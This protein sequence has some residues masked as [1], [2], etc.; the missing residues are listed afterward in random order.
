[1]P[2]PTP[3]RRS[4]SFTDYQTANPASPEP[5]NELDAQMNAVKV[6]TDSII[7]NLGL[8]QS[9]SGQLA[10]A[11][12]G[13]QQL[14]RCVLR[15]LNPPT[16][17]SSSAVSYFPGDLVFYALR[18]YV[19]NTANV[20]SASAPPSTNAAWTLLANFSSLPPGSV[21]SVDLA[22]G[23]VTSAALG[24]GLALPSSPATGDSSTAIATTAWVTAAI[25]G[26][27]GSL[28]TSLPATAGVLWSNSGVLSIS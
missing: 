26:L 17:W 4:F 15:D 28:P 23:A 21:M 3:Y 11:S 9:N 27:G 13:Y 2:S 8:I 18:F 24:P 16:M 10:N 22:P 7:S 25:A 19:C 12:V 1:M 6:T 14:Q 5:G 20:S